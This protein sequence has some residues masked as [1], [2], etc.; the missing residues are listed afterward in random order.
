MTVKLVTPKKFEIVAAA[1]VYE[2]IIVLA[3]ANSKCSSSSVMVKVSVFNNM[4]LLG[5]GGGVVSAI[6]NIVLVLI[7]QCKALQACYI[8]KWDD[9]ISP[10]LCLHTHVP[11][12]IQHIFC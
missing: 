9:I 7:C 10:Q 2:M 1:A 5:G 11:F 3:E 6:C 8:D 12:L 4:L